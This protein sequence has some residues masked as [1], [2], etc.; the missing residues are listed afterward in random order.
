[1]LRR[2]VSLR[3][4]IHRFTFCGVCS[5]ADAAYIRDAEVAL[6]RW[7]MD[8]HKRRRTIATT[9]CLLG[10]VLLASPFD[11]AAAQ[12]SISGVAT[13]RE[14]I[15]MPPDAVFEATLE[16]VSRADAPAE[17]L[18]RTRIEKPGQPPIRFT[19]AYDPAR[20][21]AKRRYSVRVLITSASELLFVTDQHYPVLGQ[22]QSNQVN[23]LL[24]KAGASTQPPPTSAAALTGLPATFAG[25][26]PCADCEALR[27]HLDLFADGVF[28]LRMTYVGKSP[29]A[30]DDI[31]KWNLGQDGRTLQL[32]GGRDAPVQF[33]IADHATLRKLDPAGKPIASQFNYDLKRQSVFAPI[34]PALRMRGA[35]AYMADA[36]A[37]TE[38]LT[39]K[40]MPVA[41]ERDNAALEAA[42]SKSRATPGGSLLATV[43]GRIAMRM[44]MEGSG[45]RP[46]L[47]V[48]R[49]HKVESARCA[50]APSTA[51]LENTHWKLMRLGTEDVTVADPQREPYLILQ[52]DQKRVAG[53]GGCNRLMGSYTL[54]GERLTFGQMAGTLM[55]CPQGMEQEK[56]FHDALAQTAR[57]GI[58]GERL[59]LFDDAGN[60][61]AQFEAAS[62]PQM[63]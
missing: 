10:L 11:P 20:I 45:P 29:E 13:Y 2:I 59:E 26:L 48:E 25:D 37:F 35:Y 32:Q 24:R 12:A 46:T 40:R 8:S 39:G 34:E 7:L 16:D 44:P 38:C 57:W 18:G 63:R 31:G 30:F 21:D 60:L 23:I 19:I 58:V 15:A 28:F 27:Y 33:Q 49:F 4:C 22:G 43:D 42:Y 55:A 54:D 52:S 56:A 1:L 53:S 17:V 14:R 41:Q 61:A 3:Q 62:A 6:Q 50:P 5:A 36:G 51:S 47:I 9:C